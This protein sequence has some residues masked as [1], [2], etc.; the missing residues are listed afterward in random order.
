MPNSATWFKV[1]FDSPY[2]HQLY[3]NRDRSEAAGFVTNLI[4]S[5]NLPKGSPILDMGCGKGRHSIL[6]NEMGYDVV[7]IDLSA[8]NI[9]AARKSA[10]ANLRFYQHDMRQPIKGVQ[11]DL[12]INLF[13]SF[14]Y[15]ESAED[16]LKVLQSAHG[17][18]AANGQFVL[19]FLNAPK[20]IEGLV[21]DE[22]RKVSTTVFHIQRKVED[23]IIIKEIQVNNDPELVFEE[24][25]QALTREELFDMFDRAGFIPTA[26]FGSYSLNPFDPETSERLIII[27]NKKK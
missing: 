27:A 15:F 4:E 22:T 19:D 24:R 13:T 9:E 16:N 11:F 12:V 20:A 5:L 7:G 23:G 10:T 21:P 3:K 14:G 25:V 18:L 1:W 26:T 8:A 17:M 6:L 2:Y